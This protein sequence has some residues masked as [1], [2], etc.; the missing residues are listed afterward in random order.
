VEQF[1]T[2]LLPKHVKYTFLD[3]L[4]LGCEMFIKTQIWVTHKKVWEPLL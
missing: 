3:V 2:F 1:E 4:G